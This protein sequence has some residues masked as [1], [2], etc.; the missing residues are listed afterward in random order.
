VGSVHGAKP[1]ADGSF[2]CYYGPE[3]PDGVAEENCVRTKPGMGFFV[4]LRL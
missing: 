2:D 4:Y 3:L 1:N